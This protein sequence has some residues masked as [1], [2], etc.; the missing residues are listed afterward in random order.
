MGGVLA[1]EML[2]QLRQLGKSADT[3]ILVDN[4]APLENTVVLEDEVAS[5]AQ[6]SYDLVA[7]DDRVSGL[8]SVESLGLSSAP[9][10]DML[11]ALQRLSVV[12]EEQS[13]AEFSE[14]FGVYQRN[15]RALA[16]YRPQL[17]RLALRVV[18]HLIRATETNAHLQA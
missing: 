10:Q 1:I 18:V 2:L 12:P 15:L 13:L 7:H 17:G 5:L 6:F 4:P 16:A 9:R 11:V 3:V 8:P 14:S